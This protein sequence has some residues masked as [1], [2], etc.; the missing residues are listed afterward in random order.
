MDF[1]STIAYCSWKNRLVSMSLLQKEMEIHGR[2]S[3][4]ALSPLPP[5]NPPENNRKISLRTCFQSKIVFDSKL[6]MP[7]V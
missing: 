5:T 6:G 2:Q 7:K 3:A 1:K 4:C